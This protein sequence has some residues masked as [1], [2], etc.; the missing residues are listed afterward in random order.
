MATKP[1]KSE[2]I[3]TYG[4][5]SFRIVKEDSHIQIFDADSKAEKPKALWDS[6]KDKGHYFRWFR[7][8]R[9]KYQ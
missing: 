1:Y 5:K 6:E 9:K 3:V 2:K 8:Q 7:E 4:K